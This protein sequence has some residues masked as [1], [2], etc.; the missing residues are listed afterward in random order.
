[1]NTVIWIVQGLLALVFLGAGVSK[2]TQPYPKLAERMGY[3]EDFQPHVIR[4][5]GLVEVLGA[6]G[7]VLP[8]LTGIFAWLTPAA[9]LGL[10][11]NMA[12]AMSVHLRRQEY[13]MLV[14]NVILMALALFVAFSRGGVFFV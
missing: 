6:C 13:P 7:V 2:L 14:G 8:A 12:G 10:A 4:A 3:V 5:I 1:M 9:A 11:L